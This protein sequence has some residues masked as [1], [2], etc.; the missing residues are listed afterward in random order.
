MAPE[1]AEAPAAS[2]T[3][4]SLSW[5]D[6][7]M[8]TATLL[9]CAV[10]LSPNP[11]DPDL[12]GHVQY[13]RDAIADGIAATTTYSYTADGYR[14]I[15]HENL[16]E[17]LLAIGA[18]TIGPIGMLCVKCLLG[19]GIIALILWQARRNQVGIVAASVA[20]ML[21]AVNLSYFWSMRPQVL[22][23]VYYTLLMALLSW[24]FAGWEGK[25]HIS[26]LRGRGEATPTLEYSS[27][28]MR[29]LWLAPLLFFFWA[30]SHG[31]FVA[32]YCIYVAYLVLRGGEVLAARGRESYGLLRRFALM[33]VTAGLATLIN[34]YGPRLHLWLLES[35]RVPRPEILEWHAPDM[36]STTML[37]VWL[38]I[39]TWFAVLLLSKRSRD[40]THLAIL[41]L[42]LWQSLEHVRH[43][44][45]FA[46]AF[47]FWMAPHIESVLRRFNVVSNAAAF[48]SDMSPAMKKSF[49]AVLALAFLLLGY[50][51]MTVSA[52]C[53][54]SDRSI[55]CPP[56]SFWQTANC[57]V[58]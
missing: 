35:L 32:G 27:R 52:I 31:G 45:F 23:F 21:V 22:S 20:G 42:T 49:A 18:D 26:W 8:I 19:T 28:R 7:A 16:A 6:R 33:V 15:N 12:W 2:P 48:G 25:C 30:N 38:I 40:V 44:P 1:N 14:W 55:R 56:F 13:G 3:P 51:S 36:T 47:G 39:F 53:P 37:P 57:T 50:T 11:A 29:F 10:A 43:I 4:S 41:T 58:N 24:C 34:P 46:I 9:T 54:S 17:I 5:F